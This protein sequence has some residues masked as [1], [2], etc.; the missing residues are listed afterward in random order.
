VGI[1]G[2]SSVAVRGLVLGRADAYAGPMS[3]EID[4]KVAEGLHARGD[5]LYNHFFIH[6]IK[7][8]AEHPEMTDRESDFIQRREQSLRESR[9]GMRK[10][11]K[12]AGHLEASVEKAWED[13]AIYHIAKL[14]LTFSRFMQRMIFLERNADTQA[15]SPNAGQTQP[16]PDHASH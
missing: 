7:C 10:S 6:W 2:P 4:P 5:E 3:D 1:F 12:R 15:S 9:E 11:L 13:W 8:M 14:E 16:A